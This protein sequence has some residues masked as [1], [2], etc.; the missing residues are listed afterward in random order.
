MEAVILARGDDPNWG[1]WFY[2]SR[3]RTPE[4]AA[5]RAAF[6]ILRDIMDRF[7]QELATAVAG[8]FPRGDL[9]TAVWD[10]AE[11]RAL[12]RGLGECQ[13]SDNM[14]MSTMVAVMKTY[15]G[16]ERSLRCMSGALSQARDD[17]R[18]L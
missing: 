13:N 14:A 8:V 7:P 3:G 12:E 10:Q 6:A 15:D 11:G 17:R 16:L 9:T 1:G 18:Q 2:E 5:S 4:E